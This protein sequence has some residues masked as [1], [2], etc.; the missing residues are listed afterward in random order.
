MVGHFS[1]GHVTADPTDVI[2]VSLIAQHSL[3]RPL[4]QFRVSFLDISR[5]AEGQRCRAF[6]LLVR[7]LDEL[8]VIDLIDG[9]LGLEGEL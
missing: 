3:Q 5:M 7:L 9:G 2:I 1:L 6:I 8:R 4:V